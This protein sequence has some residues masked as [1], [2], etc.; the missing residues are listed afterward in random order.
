M[1]YERRRIIPIV[2]FLTKDD[3]HEDMYS[4]VSVETQKN[5]RSVGTFAVSLV[6]T[7]QLGSHHS[8]RDLQMFFYEQIGPMDVVEIAF[9]R[10]DKET[11]VFTGIVDRVAKT[12]SVSGDKVRAGVTVSGRDFQKIFI[13]NNIVYH[14][15]LESEHMGEKLK[16]TALEDLLKHLR[17]GYL[18]PNL[19]TWLSQDLRE[20]IRFIV[21]DVTVGYRGKVVVSIDKQTGKMNKKPIRDFIDTETGITPD[22]SDRIR[23]ENASFQG[24]T[25]DLL[26]VV[27]GGNYVFYEIFVVTL[28]KER[29]AA[30]LILRPKPF[31]PSDWLSLK[32]WDDANKDH[33]RIEMTDVK[34]HHLG[35]SDLDTATFFKIVPANTMLEQ[36]SEHV[37]EP[38]M[39]LEEMETYG[40]RAMGLTTTLDKLKGMTTDAL[41][42]MQ[43]RIKDWFKFNPWFEAGMV[44]LGGNEAI[45][46]GEKALLPFNRIRWSDGKVYPESMFYIEGVKH[47][48]R[49]GGPFLTR[50][51][52][53]RGQPNDPS[54]WGT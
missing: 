23:A 28:T 5:I 4:V 40:L 13:E 53:T 9:R 14:P 3:I 25:W 38:E 39:L 54:I 51:K 47:T 34:E 35:R 48:W 44:T 27:L 52:L 41:R 50:L 33:H 43:R 37:V 31:D 36:D 8:S 29:P 2:R 6:A 17:L 10:E 18:F 42:E 12:I 7:P 20:A 22:M 30:K 15:M 21:E 16:G 19:E 32:T 46:I 11:K 1:T 49:I 26:R 24:R 45:K